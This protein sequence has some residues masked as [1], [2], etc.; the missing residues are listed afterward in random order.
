MSRFRFEEYDYGYEVFYRGESLGRIVAF[1]EASGRPCF[2]LSC[3]DRKEPRT[4]RGK[5]QAAEALH[6]VHRLKQEYAARRWPVDTL[7]VRAWDRRPS[8][9]KNPHETR[10]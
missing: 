7:I 4:Y 2:A 1:R 8:S 10:S 5:V 6:D 9:V 3:D